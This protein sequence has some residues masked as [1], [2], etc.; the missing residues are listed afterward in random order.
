MSRPTTLAALSFLLL[1]LGACQST[2]APAPSQPP[3]AAP[4]TT[5]AA[6]P[7]RDPQSTV[8]PKSEP[9]EGQKLLA[10]M[11]GQ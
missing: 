9:G 1:P 6:P 4:P 5:A 3:A 7:P 8:E 11:V 10:R 2:P